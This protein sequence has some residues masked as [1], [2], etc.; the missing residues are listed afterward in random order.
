MANIIPIVLAGGSGTR[1]WPLSRKSHPKQ[2][3]KISNEDNSLF[4]NT[5]YRLPDNFSKPIVICNEEHRFIAAEQLRE[6]GVEPETII[7]ES[8]GKNTAPAIAL[9]AFE[10][11][12]ID[13]DAVMLVLAS[14]HDIKNTK[15]FHKC[16]SVAEKGALENYLLTFGIKPLRPD[17]NYGYI[18]A[19]K[20][21]SD[22]LHINSF[23]EKPSIELAKNYISKDNYFWNSGMFA[24]KAKIYLEELKKFE[25]EIYECCKQAMSNPTKDHDF[26]RLN[27][28]IFEHCPEKSIDIGVME[29]TKN[30]GMVI[31]DAEWSD[32]G[33]WE[34]IWH[35]TSKTKSGNVEYG[36]IISINSKNSLIYSPNQLT[37]TIG[38]E[39]LAVINTPDALLI[40]RIK[41]VGNINQLLTKLKSLNRKEL[42]DNNLVYRPWGYFNSIICHQ[43]Y[44][45]KI[46][47]INPGAKISLQKHEHRSEHWI[48][49]SG[50]ATITKGE[51]TFD[52]QINQSTFIPSGEIHRLSNLQNNELKIIEIQS[53]N[54]L[55][56]DDI[57]RLDDIYKR[58]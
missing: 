36:D 34:S 24:F 31:L 13:P 12:T 54:Y 35:T 15:E 53:G 4:Q 10:I 20:H 27:F 52:L 49:I 16:L 25:P 55:G 43:N 40:S 32:L 26:T 38:I 14:D 8:I 21:S 42:T 44:Q 46:I 1:L 45:I 50:V 28:A 7:L 33:T 57:V 2:F 58:S 18:K 9:A 47:S 11:L 19:E 41:D 30:G 48:V 17:T 23:K 6:I 56:E 37:S 5:F 3:I 29:K 22:I 51:K 39:D